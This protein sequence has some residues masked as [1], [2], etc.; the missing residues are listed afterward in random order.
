[1]K[2]VKIIFIF[3]A[4]V[5]SLS[6]KKQ[7][8]DLQIE[9]NAVNEVFAEIVD[10][11]YM[12]RRIILPP[13]QPK[14]NFKTNK[15]DIIGNKKQLK[16]YWLHHD[17]I[18]NDTSK[19]AIAVNDYVEKIWKE[20]KKLIIESYKD[21]EFTY[22]DS[23]DLKRFKLELKTFKKNKK[24]TFKYLSKFPEILYW[25]MYDNMLP[26]GE[27][28]ISR[29]QFNKNYTSGILAASS[30]CGGGKCGR[31][32]LIVIKKKFGKWKVAKITQTWVS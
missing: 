13:P 18:K 1:M 16:N 25:N 19:I 28:T 14:L 7:L 10:S 17:S 23:K 26:V 11:I 31:G 8:S 6:C 21:S 32:F 3:L 20:D 27:I 30:S 12:D 2:I 24:F 9:S 15:E 4:L 22:D 5:S 29:I